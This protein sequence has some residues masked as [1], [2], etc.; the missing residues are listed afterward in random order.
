MNE[1]ES[2]TPEGLA[3][4]VSSID[5]RDQL[6][7]VEKSYRGTDPLLADLLSM[8]R[9]EISKLHAQIT[10]TEGERKLLAR[11]VASAYIVLY[12]YDGYYDEK[13]KTG[14]VEGLAAIVQQASNILNGSEDK[15][16]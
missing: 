15:I 10:A 12:D 3:V 6:A 5:L 9:T 1:K 4:N 7:M 13:M 11:R 14:N 8:C 16:T 2:N